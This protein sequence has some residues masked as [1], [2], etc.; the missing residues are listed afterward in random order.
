MADIANSWRLLS[1]ILRQANIRRTTA[2]TSVACTRRVLMS[3]KIR[4][5]TCTFYFKFG[6]NKIFRQNCMRS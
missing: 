5:M 2:T 3:G 6:E 1:Q 4:L